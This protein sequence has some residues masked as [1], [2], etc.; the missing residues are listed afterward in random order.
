MRK[1]S[2]LLAALAFWLMFAANVM[3]AEAANP[4][5]ILMKFTDDT[6]FDRIESAASLSDLVMEKLIMTGKFNLKETRPIDAQIEALLYDEKAHRYSAPCCS[7][8]CDIILGEIYCPTCAVAIDCALPSLK[9]A[10]SNIAEKFPL[11]IACFTPCSSCAF[12]P[13]VKKINVSSF[14]ASTIV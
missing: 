12:L 10:P 4:T 13:R 11:S 7:P 9:P 6:R 1:K 8:I 2:R 3:Q 14:F 5:C